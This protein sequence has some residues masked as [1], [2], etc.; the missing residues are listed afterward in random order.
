MLIKSCV[1]INIGL[2][3]SST[4]CTH[5]AQPFISYSEVWPGHK[6][7][8]ICI[9][10]IQYFLGKFSHIIFLQLGFLPQIIPSC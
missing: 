4:V 8:N 7:T 2:D 10:R 9:L 3:S 1:W 5:N 6:F